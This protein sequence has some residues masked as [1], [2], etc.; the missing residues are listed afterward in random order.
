MILRYIKLAII[1]FFLAAF[2]FILLFSFR[3]INQDADAVGYAYST[4]TGT[5]MFH[6][7]HL[8][9]IPVLRIFFLALS[10]FCTSCGA[11]FA[12]QVHNIL[13]AVIT[14]LLFFFIARRFLNSAFMG[15]LAAL[16]FLV[17]QGFW[18]A[19]T[20]NL[21]YIPATGALALLVAFLVFCG[22]SRAG[23]GKAAVISLLLAASVFYHQANILFCIPLGYYLICAGG[24]KGTKAF[25]TVIVLT[26]LIVL[27]AYVLVVA[28]STHGEWDIY[29]LVEFLLGYASRQQP[30][31]GTFKNFSSKCVDIFLDG[32][33][34]SI[35]YFPYCMRPVIGC[36]FTWFIAIVIVW[37][38]IQSMR[39]APYGK[40]RGLLV[41][42]LISYA[43][44]FLWWMPW[45]KK[46]Q[47]MILFPA[48]LLIFLGLRDVIDILRNHDYIRGFTSGAAIV[49]VIAIAGMNFSKTILPQ[50]QLTS[51]GYREAAR[52]NNLAPADCLICADYE[53][54]QCMAYYFD[55][56]KVFVLQDS[57]LCFYQGR[58]L[59]NKYRF[60][61]HEKCIVVHV[62]Y[63]TPGYICLTNGYEDPTGWLKFMEW[64]FD[65]EYD[66]QHRLIRCRQFDMKNVEEGGLYIF[67]HSSK[68]DVDGFKG[69]CKILDNRVEK[70]IGD[71]AILFQGWYYSLPVLRGMTAE[72]FLQKAR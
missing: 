31:W 35:A 33:L 26:G 21:P 27:S 66:P 16:L 71:K 52:L 40:V 41:L 28:M 13:W 55:R 3:A 44:F 58:P 34:W 51:K 62:T 61:K 39:K 49:A 32:G 6:P 23:L 63:I 24:K 36:M 68:M 17:T 25:A 54:K 48:L 20:Q 4:K 59:P 38:I 37:N 11:L 50:H 60:V 29:K 9:Y 8:L 14:V 57:L 56:K 42:W 45:E 5:Y 19:S 22:P 2:T 72:Q 30:G 1:A 46:Y 64:I 7:H 18:W 15:V 70:F 47:I 53:T 10:S 65:F 12:G 67:L 69:L 43:L